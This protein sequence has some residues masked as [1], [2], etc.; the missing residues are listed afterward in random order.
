MLFRSG[1]AAKQLSDAW[2]EMASKSEALADAL[3]SAVEAID[4]L[5]DYILGVKR[6]NT[7]DEDGYY[8]ERPH[9]DEMD[10]LTSAKK[11]GEA[12]LNA[13]DR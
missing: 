9:K 2:A 13:V 4:L 12:A 6:N 1:D 3:V 7:P 8:Y 5:D 10:R 11:Q